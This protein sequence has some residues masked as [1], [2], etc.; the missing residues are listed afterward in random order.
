[1]GLNSAEPRVPPPLFR[2]RFPI[3]LFFSEPQMLG[4][5]LAFIGFGH[6]FSFIP[7]DTEF[8]PGRSFPER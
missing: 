2:R 7:E 3:F 8:P 1:V 4:V 5:E 6:F